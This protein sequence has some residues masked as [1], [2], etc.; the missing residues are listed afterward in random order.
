MK[1]PRI[2]PGGVAAAHIHV[3]F[4]VM[5]YILEGRVRHEYGPTPRVLR[6]QRGRRLH[7]HRARRAARGVQRER[8]R[9]RR[10]RRRPIRRER[11]GAHR[12]VCQRP[13]E[14]FPLRSAPG[15]DSRGLHPLS[16]PAAALD[17]YRRAPTS[18]LGRL[19]DAVRRQKHPEG[20]SR[21][22]STATSTT[23][24]SA[25]RAASSARSTGRSDR[26]KATRS[27]STRST[28]RSTRRFG[29]AAGSCCCRA[30]TI[31]TFRWQW[32]EDLFRGVKQRY[33]EFRLHALSPPEV[34]HISRLSQLPVPDGHR[35]ADRRRARQHSRRRRRD[36]RRSRPQ[37]PELLQQGHRRRVAG[38]DARTRI[39]PA[40]ARRRR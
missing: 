5:L 15:N 38:R 12:A 28:G 2:P 6:H 37:D 35:A 21:T 10:C 22:S 17:L 25:S 31:P 3:G 40:C 19:A 1:S 24:T 9:S 18:E 39:A 36:S 13:R 29:S 14:S 20:S 32:Y 7:L 30:A 11:V 16:P 4:E 8:H 26:P 34:I 23:R 33:P 27:A